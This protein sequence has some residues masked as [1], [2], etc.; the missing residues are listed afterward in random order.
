[1]LKIKKIKDKDV[2]KVVAQDS[3]PCQYAGHKGA[4]N[5]LYDCTTQGKDRYYK[6]KDL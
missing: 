6:S 1:M 2:A 4:Y 5:C 3:Q